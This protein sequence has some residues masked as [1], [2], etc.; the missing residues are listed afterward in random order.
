MSYTQEIG[1]SAELKAR[2][3]LIKQG[4]KWVA[5]NYRCRF[6]EIDLVMR[7]GDCTIFVEVRTRS[8]ILYGGA[9]AS[10]TDK[11]QKK[12]LKTAS[13]YLISNK[14]NENYPIRFDILSFEGIPPQI[15]W[16]KNAFG[17]NF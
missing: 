5:S 16:V 8:S 9:L 2:A 12:L 14:M 13:Y 1:F 15:E 11:K 3:Y 7:D 17:L 10:V 4:L 6:G